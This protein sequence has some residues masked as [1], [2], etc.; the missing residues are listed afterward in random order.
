MMD[1]YEIELIV[2]RLVP[3]IETAE[4]IKNKTQIFDESKYL[5]RNRNRQNSGVLRN[6]FLILTSPIN[7]T[8]GMNDRVFSG[9]SLLYKDQWVLV[10]QYPRENLWDVYQGGY[11]TGNLPLRQ[12]RV[13]LVDFF[14]SRFGG[15]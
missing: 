3:P 15:R 13:S 12:E 14:K 4:T 1:V 7:K 2:R 11:P 6:E 5:A 10:Q 8:L 9:V